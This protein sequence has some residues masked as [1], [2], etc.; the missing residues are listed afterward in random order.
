MKQ[1]RWKSKVLWASLAAQ[2][3]A[4]LQLLGVFAKLGLNAGTVGN[5]VAGLLQLFVIF[6]VLNDPTTADGF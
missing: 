1:S 2:V 3:I 4:L 6:G 5:I